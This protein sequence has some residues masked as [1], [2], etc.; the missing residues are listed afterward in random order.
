MIGRNSLITYPAVIVFVKDAHKLTGL[1]LELVIHR[2]LKVKLHAVHIVR[3]WLCSGMPPTA[4]MDN[5][6]VLLPSLYAVMLPSL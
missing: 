3:S 4:S 1:Q 2:G 6:Y 5:K